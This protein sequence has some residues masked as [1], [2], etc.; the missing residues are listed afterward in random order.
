MD[1]MDQW[2]IFIALYTLSSGNA[3]SK[4]DNKCAFSSRHRI[5]TN[6]RLNMW[7]AVTPATEIYILLRHRNQHPRVLSAFFSSKRHRIRYKFAYWVYIN[8][9]TCLAFQCKHIHIISVCIYA[10]HQHEKASPDVVAQVYSY[11]ALICLCIII[12]FKAAI[13]CSFTTSRCVYIFYPGTWRVQGVLTKIEAYNHVNGNRTC[14]CLTARILH[15]SYCTIGRILKMLRFLSHRH[16]HSCII[17][18]YKDRKC[19]VYI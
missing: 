8:N 4:P 16:T 7:R 17:S 19:N 5:I 13:L 2:P 14:N 11:W 18:C 3:H 15:S 9:N 6:L 12:I 10:C 1:V